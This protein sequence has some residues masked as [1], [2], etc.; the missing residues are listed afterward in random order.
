LIHSVHPFSASAVKVGEIIGW[1]VG[2]VL[3]L[4]LMAHQ[5]YSDCVLFKSS[6][7]ISA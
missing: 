2:V 3:V 4:P 1:V 7:T 5:L 6:N